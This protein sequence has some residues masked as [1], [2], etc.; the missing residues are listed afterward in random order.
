MSWHRIY[1]GQYMTLPSHRMVINQ[2][3]CST[4]GPFPDTEPG[5]GEGPTLNIESLN[6]DLSTPKKETKICFHCKAFLPW[7]QR[8]WCPA[9]F[10]LFISAHILFLTQIYPVDIHKYI[11]F[12]KQIY[13]VYK[14]NVSCFQSKYINITLQSRNILAIHMSP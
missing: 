9:G 3:F 4:C 13:P 5:K 11:L 7:W 2:Y 12:A 1:F 10:C 6:I 8:F 14:A